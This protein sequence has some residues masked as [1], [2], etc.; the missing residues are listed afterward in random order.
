[1]ALEAALLEEALA[2]QELAVWEQAWDWEEASGE[3]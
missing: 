1:M 3:E 2:V